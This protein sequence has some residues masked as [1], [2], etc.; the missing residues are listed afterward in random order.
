MPPSSSA[1][2]RIDWSSLASHLSPAPVNWR[3]VHGN[4]D[5]YYRRA[6]E[7]GYRARSAYK[8]LQVD[9]AHSVFSPST[10]RVV[11]LCAAPGSWSQV[12]AERLAQTLPPSPTPRVISVDLQEMSP[13]PGVQLLQGDVTS[14]AVMERIL[15]YFA[16]EK[17][18]LVLCDGAPD[19]TGLHAIDEYVQG[20][21]LESVLRV[22]VRMLR[23]GGIFVAKIF[24]DEAY[25][26][27]QSAELLTRCDGGGAWRLG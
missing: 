26:I 24:R 20:Q 15:A 1:S 27:L 17:A 22:T 8:L 3:L 2:S 10:Q 16:P 12:A 11:D 13:I 21:L 25:D 7:S 6:K 14:A 4:R 5:I 18:D 19:V 9:D 23:E